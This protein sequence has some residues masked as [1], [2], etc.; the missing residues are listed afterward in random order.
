[1]IYATNQRHNWTALRQ[2]GRDRSGKNPSHRGAL[3][4][5]VRVRWGD[6]DHRIKG[7][8]RLHP[9]LRMYTAGSYIEEGFPAWRKQRGGRSGK[10]A[11]IQHLEQNAPTVLKPKRHKVSLVGRARCSR[12]RRMGRL[13]SIQG[14]GAEHR[15]CRAPHYRSRGQRQG[16]YAVQLPVGDICGAADESKAHE[17]HVTAPLYG[18]VANRVGAP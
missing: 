16:L 9:K 6:C 13:P 15:L 10:H 18:W 3:A 7:P 12:L 5:Q 2:V 1:M 8:F 11:P 17:G 4:T 14:M